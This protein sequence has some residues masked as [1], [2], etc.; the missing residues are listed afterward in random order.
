MPIAGHWRVGRS[1]RTLIDRD[2]W[3]GEVI[4][5][6][7]EA[8]ASDVED[9]C[10]AAGIAQHRWSQSEPERRAAVMS[11]AADLV[12][13]QRDELARWLTR[14]TGATAGRVELELG[15][16]RSAFL[17]AA[18]L[19]DQAASRTLPD[20]TTGPRLRVHRR[21][22]GV[23]CVLGP[24]DF[25]LYLTTRVLAPALAL[26]NAV[27]LK[28]SSHTPVTGGLLLARLLEQA[29][30]P[31][32]VLNVVIGQAAAIGPALVAHPIPRVISLTGSATSAL[33][34]ARAA[35]LKR[36]LLDVGGNVPM[37]VL[38]DADLEYTVESAMSGAFFPNGQ[39]RMAANRV[40]VDAALHD[41]FVD[42]FVER[43]RAL[44]L[45]DPSDPATAVGP[46][47]SRHHLDAVRDKIER[48]TAQGAL[49]LLGGDPVG[50]AGLALPPHVLLATNDV[51][52]AQEEV[53]GPVLTIIRARDEHE[54]A[55][56]A[57]DA[58]HT[59]ASVVHTRDSERG[60][61]FAS[62][63][64]AG[65]THVSRRG[66]DESTGLSEPVHDVSAIDRFTVDHTVTLY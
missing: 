30:L 24:W 14:E 47:V 13:T 28:P 17:A 2:P 21:P 62:R 63:L 3:S 65:T 26:G 38:D 25:P 52:T 37:V 51:A 20:D 29:G 7:A 33:H 60:T 15:V 1:D 55:L 58:V 64:R 53:F 49:M 18:A 50:P 43:A 32:G 46:M 31:D 48:S 66:A 44:V 10:A 54:A 39:I 5:E 23:V 36:L 22:A 56:L 45:G 57:N 40:I 27:V 19:P 35:G 6:L 9:A 11:A 59:P 16:L 4:L 42:K 61:R 8:D 12:I 34:V 41:E